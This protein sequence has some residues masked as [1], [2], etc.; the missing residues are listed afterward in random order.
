MAP[1]PFPRP[2]MRPL[3]MR[4]QRIRNLCLERYRV[5]GSRFV[6][7]GASWGERDWVRTEGRGA[8]RLPWLRNTLWTAFREPSPL[9]LTTTQ[10]GCRFLAERRVYRPC[11]GKKGMFWAGQGRS[12]ESS[13]LGY[14]PFVLLWKQAWRFFFKGSILIGGRSQ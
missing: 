7:L 6:L 10:G 2:I 5:L 14:G 4:S 11:A 3:I 8:I 12:L 1:H 13:S 9:T